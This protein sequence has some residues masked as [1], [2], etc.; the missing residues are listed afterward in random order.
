[1]DLNAAAP[2]YVIEG[3]VTDGSGPQQVRIIRTKNFDENNT[4][5]GV[6]NAEV[7]IADDAGNRE[8]LSYIEKGFYETAELAAIPGRTYFLTVN[9]GGETYTADST[10]PELGSFDSLYVEEIPTLG[11][12]V[13]RPTV[14][15]SDISGIRNFY[16]YNLYVNK[17]KTRL[18]Y[19]GTEEG[20][21][22]SQIEWGLSYSDE[23]DEG[24]LESGDT[25]TVEVQAVDEEVYNYFFSLDQTISQAVATPANPVSN[26]SGGALGYFSAHSAKTKTVMLD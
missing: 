19:I 17:V 16:K 2:K 26:I 5:E 12:T 7:I 25:V 21:D 18:I 1:M 3:V 22:G 23:N 4:F 20:N 24:E 6:G 15:L 14:L 11:V 8:V 9:V 10:M 13:R